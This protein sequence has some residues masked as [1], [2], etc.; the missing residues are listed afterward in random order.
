MTG[1]I[2]SRLKETPGIVLPAPPAPVVSY[3]FPR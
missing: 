2:D 3:A 1:R